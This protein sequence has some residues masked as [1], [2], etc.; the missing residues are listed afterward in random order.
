MTEDEATVAALVRVL[1][2]DAEALEP[3][4]R[5][6]E[7]RAR[8]HRDA[9]RRPVLAAACAALVAGGTAVGVGLLGR[10]PGP[11]APAVPT[12]VTSAATPNPSGSASGSTPSPTTSQ[13]LVTFVLPVY[14]LGQDGERLALY[15][16][17]HRLQLADRGYVWR[18]G[19]WQNNA[20]YDLVGPLQLAVGEAT[21]PTAVLD[22]DL[23]S[24]WQLGSRAAV[25][26]DQTDRVVTI[27]L[28]AHEGEAHGRTAE[29][30]RLAVQQLVW[31]VTAVQQ[32]ADL[33]VRL[34]VDGRPGRLFGSVPVGDVVHRASP[35]YD[36][37][38]S[39]WVEA[40]D[41]GQ[42]VSGPVT[43]RGSACTFEAN[44]GW[45]LL[46]DGQ[47]VD[48]GST[49]ASSGCPSRGSWSVAL[50]RLEPGGYTFRAFES[51]ASGQGPDRE[52][53]RSFV[54]R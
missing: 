50:G 48:S 47:V 38:G 11:T 13:H 5:L 54:V 8:T 51:P 52:D 10:D 6:A 53:T 2:H 20:I 29:Q 27:D 46:R 12:G 36:V 3:S 28:P 19:A 7:L 32:D 33:G 34:L 1:D 49:T 41:E 4:D 37:L 43:L 16:E 31:T 42:Q 39:L 23:A 40:P 26:V 30:A 22:P 15:R 17:F 14:Y 35:S 24:P 45:Q 44:V 9:R 18:D 21:K 25:V